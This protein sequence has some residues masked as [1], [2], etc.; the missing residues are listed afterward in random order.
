MLPVAGAAIGLSVLTGRQNGQEPYDPN[1][2]LNTRPAK[3]SLAA[4]VDAQAQ[5]QAA[6]DAAAA[7][8]EAEA[9]AEE[10]AAAAAEEEAEAYAAAQ[11]QA[12]AE[13]EAYAQA[14]AYADAK[15]EAYKAY[16]VAPEM[17]ARGLPQFDDPQ[18]VAPKQ[19]APLLNQPLNG[20]GPCLAPLSFVQPAPPPP[21]PMVPMPFLRMGD[22]NLPL[23]N[24]AENQQM[25]TARMMRMQ[26]YLGTF[27]DA[28]GVY[29]TWGAVPNL[30]TTDLRPHV[31][32]DRVP[33]HYMV[34]RWD[35]PGVIMQ[36]PQTQGSLPSEAADEARRRMEIS[37]YAGLE[38]NA[39]IHVPVLREEPAPPGFWQREENRVQPYL[40]TRRG[41]DTYM[42]A[43]MGSDVLPD[44]AFRHV[45]PQADTQYHLADFEEIME[46]AP[47]DRGH[48]N[49]VRAA[50]PDCRGPANPHKGRDRLAPM[51]PRSQPDMQVG[52][53]P[54]ADPVLPHGNKVRDM[55]TRIT[56]GDVELDPAAGMRQERLE[57]GPDR[58]RLLP[59][60][61]RDTGVGGGSNGA[62]K[63]R[64]R[65]R[66]VE[67]DPAHGQARY[68]EAPQ[69]TVAVTDAL[70]A[71][72][73]VVP[74]LRSST[75]EPGARRP[76][77]AAPAGPEGGLPG[78]TPR[79]TL[80]SGFFRSRMQQ[81]G[82]EQR[83]DR[84]LDAAP[85]RGARG[86]WSVRGHKNVGPRATGAI[87]RLE[88]R[89]PLAD[90]CEDSA[91]MAPRAQPLR[92]KRFDD[93][94]ETPE[95]RAV[96]LS[97]ADTKAGPVS[98]PA[99]LQRR[100]TSELLDFPM[101]VGRPGGGAVAARGLSA[102]PID[103]TLPRKGLSAGPV[104]LPRM[105]VTHMEG[106]WSQQTRPSFLTS[107]R[108]EETLTGKLADR[109]LQRA[110]A[111]ENPGKMQARPTYDQT[112]VRGRKMADFLAQKPKPA[113]NNLGVREARRVFQTY[114]PNKQQGSGFRLP[115]PVF[116]A[117]GPDV[118]KRFGP[119]A[120]LKADGAMR[121]SAARPMRPDV[122]TA[123]QIVAGMGRALACAT[124]EMAFD[125]QRAGARRVV[126]M[127][128]A[129]GQQRPRRADP[130]LMRGARP[131]NQS[132]GLRKDEWVT[133]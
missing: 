92:S 121:P 29:D 93:F 63:A 129:Q 123:D 46:D 34:D 64:H 77:A 125:S 52:R 22:S 87:E 133:A 110:S 60:H 83:A 61:A 89:R 19:F 109:A 90:A 101:N 104:V 9:Y 115:A 99:R 84:D 13:E 108:K 62:Y 67:L 53:F 23:V 57:G 122:A 44:G 86:Q 1:R 40:P 120:I 47:K 94:E 39:G 65:Q 37:A 103:C 55:K 82:R 128:A 112:H 132:K 38:E 68:N 21:A 5:A 72:P 69:R 42:P 26:P 100:A 118:T 27:E 111:P 3:T 45:G 102:R 114:V 50:R 107:K 17:V 74:S 131:R 32:N 97:A 12:Y 56:P 66:D 2:F 78:P 80:E 127:A 116:P 20:G 96:R 126:R 16:G 58:R 76:R 15:T 7:E 106:S 4:P 31:A 119:E 18:D 95:R 73:I 43:P 6:E 10:E 28:T 48:E 25:E 113:A 117:V 79:P 51:A 70:S 91:A 8:E 81:R 54:R 59:V 71:R 33:A 49:N 85:G 24:P 36:Q 124:A 130:K 88:T 105:R 11:Q 35:G 75:C 41:K 98:R 30:P 14:E